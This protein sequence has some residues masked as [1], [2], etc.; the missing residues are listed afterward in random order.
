MKKVNS[1]YVI[2]MRKKFLV[3][4]EIIKWIIKTIVETF[5][6]FVKQGKANTGLDR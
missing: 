6:L 2:C 4:Q 3:S 1:D 5:T